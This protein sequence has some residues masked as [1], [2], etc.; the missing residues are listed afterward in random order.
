MYVTREVKNS[1]EQINTNDMSG[2]SN[3]YGEKRNP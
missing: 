3:I 1:G 2:A